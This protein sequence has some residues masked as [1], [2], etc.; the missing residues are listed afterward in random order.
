MGFLSGINSELEE[1]AQIIGARRKQ[2]ADTLREEQDYQR[3]LEAEDRAFE[4]QKELIDLRNQS[5]KDGGNKLNGSLSPWTPVVGANVQQ[6]T[7]QSAFRDTSAQVNIPDNSR[8]QM[9]GGEP[10][11]IRPSFGVRSSSGLSGGLTPTRIQPSGELGMGKQLPSPEMQQLDTNND[12]KLDV[13]EMGV[14][15]KALQTIK[16][17]TPEDKKIIMKNLGDFSGIDMSSFGDIDYTTGGIKETKSSKNKYM[18]IDGKEFTEPEAVKLINK[19]DSDIKTMKDALSNAKDPSENAENNIL[20]LEDR[21]GRA[22][23]ALAKFRG[24]DVKDDKKY[25]DTGETTKE[26]YKILTDSNG[27]KFVDVPE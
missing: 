10:T 7:P 16:D 27:N 20:A 1:I 15:L 12:G 22:K 2:Q 21:K 23:K 13:K 9:G 5:G 17:Y 4:R 25:E 19:L 26:G 14:V 24:E 3:Q 11:Q 18:K 8:F 6:P